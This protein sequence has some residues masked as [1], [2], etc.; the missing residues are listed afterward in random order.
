LFSQNH[1][2]FVSFLQVIVKNDDLVRWRRS[3]V[4]LAGLGHLFKEMHGKTFRNNPFDN[5][6][7]PKL[8]VFIAGAPNSIV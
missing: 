1:T 6:E 5:F 8:R 3:R 4:I 7:I 2:I